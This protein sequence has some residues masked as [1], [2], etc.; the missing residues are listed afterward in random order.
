[1]QLT[2][3]VG[4]QRLPLSL[5]LLP[6]LLCQPCAALVG[7][8]PAARS[9]DGGGAEVGIIYDGWHT[10]AYWGRSPSTNDT[11]EEIIASNGS[12]SMGSMGHDMTLGHGGNAWWH[13]EPIDG[14]YCTYRKRLT[15]DWHWHWPS[16]CP[17]SGCQFQDCPNIEATT[18]RHATLLQEAGIDFVIFDATNAKVFDY[19]GDASQLRPFEVLCED[20]LKLRQS[21]I[22]TPQLAIWQ[23]LQNKDG[24][25]N[26]YKHYLNY[27]YADGS[28][29]E[30]LL[31]RDKKSGKK[32]FFTCVH[33][34]TPAQSLGAGR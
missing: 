23:N 32:V 10:A 18:T 21:G 8:H 9:W 34:S 27:T 33:A 13:K 22:K 7:V 11:V 31:F 6:L 3:P 1:M 24:K 5:L 20:W 25:S 15:D 4:V 26:L 12:K 2:A 17:A 14:F 28:P 16:D 29:F 30:E 19:Q